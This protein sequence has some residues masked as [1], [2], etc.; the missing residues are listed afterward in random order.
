LIAS[1]THRPAGEPKEEG[2]GPMISSSDIDG[3]EIAARGNAA[4]E[5]LMYLYKGTKQLR[6]WLGCLGHTR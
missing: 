4:I 1:L 6:V 3:G 2:D 5:I